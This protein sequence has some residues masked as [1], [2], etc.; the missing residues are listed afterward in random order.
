[1]RTQAD[2]IAPDMHLVSHRIDGPNEFRTVY[3]LELFLP[4][5]PSRLLSGAS[6]QFH[7][8]SRSFEMYRASVESAADS[9]TSF[10][11]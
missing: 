1:M 4:F 10:V 3:G 11:S 7:H 5:I 6:Y 2:D 9:S 8:I